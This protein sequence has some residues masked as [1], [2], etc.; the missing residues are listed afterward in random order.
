[1]CGCPGGEEGRA[2]HT[3]LLDY[4]TEDRSMEN[5]PVLYLQATYLPSSTHIPPSVQGYHPSGSGMK[6]DRR[7][8]LKMSSSTSILGHWDLSWDAGPG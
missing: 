6:M 2:N 4:I 1:M 8:T 7:S 3:T 5:K